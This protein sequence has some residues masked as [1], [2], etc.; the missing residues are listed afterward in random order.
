MPPVFSV[1]Q[2]AVARSITPESARVLCSRYTSSGLFIRLKRDTYLLRERWDYLGEEE[3]FAMANRI[4]VPS[5]ISLSTALSYYGLTTQLQQ[6][7][8]ESIA[9]Q[10][11]Y[12]TTVLE[13]EFNFSKL[14][15][16]YYSSFQ[17]VGSFFIATPE[18]ALADA[19]YLC[20]LGRY[21]LDMSALEYDRIDEAS[22]RRALDIFP[23]RTTEQWSKRAKS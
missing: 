22:L 10:R 8:Y 1:G 13:L 17:K 15:Q 11:S 23:E 3:L 20:S 14:P 7:V 5:Y 18:K 6:G 21:S 19:L 4:Q 2:V 12:S 9:V 16:A